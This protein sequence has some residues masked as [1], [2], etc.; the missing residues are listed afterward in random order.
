MKNGSNVSTA[1]LKLR[2]LARMLLIYQTDLD[3]SVVFY[4]KRF[5]EGG[6]LSKLLKKKS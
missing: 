6:F 3:K 4:F 5:V 1:V 2:L